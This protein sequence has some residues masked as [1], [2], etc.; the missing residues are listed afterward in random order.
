MPVGLSPF[1]DL[2]PRP[3]SSLEPNLP[4][5][6]RPLLHPGWARSVAVRRVIA[7]LLVVLAAVF[8]LRN[9]PATERTAVVVAARDL[10]PG[11]ALTADDVEFADRD[12]SA[13]VTGTLTDL[14][15]A[16]GH[17]LAGPVPAGEA[18]VDTRILGPR[19]AAAA[20]G[21]DDA[22]VVPI[23]LADAGVG[24]LLRAGDK[25]DVLTVTG[26]SDAAM[27]DA[28]VLARGAVVVLAQHEESSDQRERVIL[29]ALEQEQA[30]SVAAASL[31]SALTVTLH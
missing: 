7:A 30:M 21:A 13:L 17:T 4:D 23:R 11:V 2:A 19:L 15:D 31:T 14:A 3:A 25:V 16:L 28:H 10:T 20:V 8:A 24:R 5:R 22:R 9:D 18:L 29:V 1:R 12:T 6:I 26:E 27:G